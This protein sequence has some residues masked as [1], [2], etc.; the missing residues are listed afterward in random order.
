MV[1]SVLWHTL[2][3]LSQEYFIKSIPFSSKITQISVHRDR[4]DSQE[5]MQNL[6]PEI[7]FVRVTGTSIEGSHFQPQKDITLWEI[8]SSAYDLKI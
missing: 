2:S 1:L 5:N 7:Y 6:Y 3:N 4:G 8:I